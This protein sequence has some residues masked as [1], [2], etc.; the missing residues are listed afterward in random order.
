VADKRII[1]VTGATGS[2]GGGLVRAI[3]D[4]PAG[5]FTVRVITPQPDLREGRRI[6][7]PRRLH[8]HQLLGSTHPRRGSQ[9]PPRPDGEGAGTQRGTCGKGSRPRD[10]DIARTLNPR[11]RPLDDWLLEHRD[12]MKSLVGRPSGDLT[13]S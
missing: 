3:L 4:D 12:Q 6:R 2:Q 8:R 13:V 11:L 10:L 9:T 7:H 1:A 5:P